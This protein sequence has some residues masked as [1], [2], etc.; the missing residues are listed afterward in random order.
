MD[1]TT[2]KMIEDRCRT[3]SF[4]SSTT[5]VLKHRTQLRSWPSAIIQSRIEFDAICQ[6]DLTIL[7][8]LQLARVSSLKRELIQILQEAGCNLANKKILKL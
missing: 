6:L 7:T 1:L 3:L 8:P 5:D 4:E 2:I